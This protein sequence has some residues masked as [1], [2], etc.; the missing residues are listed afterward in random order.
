M[1]ASAE[2]AAGRQ[3]LAAHTGHGHFR[4]SGCAEHLRQ[5]TE[6]AGAAASMAGWASSTV[7]LAA[8]TTTG[9]TV[10]TACLA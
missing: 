4:G 2:Y 6:M 1:C 5:L 9:A 8:S 7:F 3:E 10:S